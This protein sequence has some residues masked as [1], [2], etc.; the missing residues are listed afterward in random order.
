MNAHALAGNPTLNVVCAACGATNRVPQDR[1][2]EQPVC[3]SCRQPLFDGHPIALTEADFE[4]HAGH[5]DLP[6]V[7]DFWAP[8]CGPCRAM[9]PAFERAA[10][11]LEPAARFVKVNTD[12]ARVLAMRH[13]I[14]GIPTIAVIK[15]GREVAR[16]SGAMDAGRLIAWIRSHLQAE[17]AP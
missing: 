8:W 4:R 16:V 12:E 7:V 17:G 11:T 3:G 6:L 15:G 14:S 13:G 9:A 2:S 1:L 10:Q 5:S